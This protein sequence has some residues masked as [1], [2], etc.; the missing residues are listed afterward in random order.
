MNTIN[1]KEMQK[2]NKRK[3]N[4]DR[5]KQ[6]KTEAIVKGW[7]LNEFFVHLSYFQLTCKASLI[8]K[9]N[10]EVALSIMLKQ[11]EL[12]ESKHVGVDCRYL[13]L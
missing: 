6:G 2:H 11:R 9:S 3:A 8:P 13:K 7:E 5:N 1:E 4:K 12:Y 10:L